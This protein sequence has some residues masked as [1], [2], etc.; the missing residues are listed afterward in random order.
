VRNGKD[1]AWSG[2]GSSTELGRRDFLVQAA[3]V[4]GA[5]ALMPD[6]LPAAPVIRGA[7]MRVAVVGLGRQGRAIIAELG[8]IEATSVAALCDS[9]PSRLEAGVRRSN[10]AAGYADHRALLEKAA[11]FD[12]IIIATPTHLHK[13]IV[14]AALAAGK[15]VYCEAPLAHTIEDAEAIAK[16]A[17]GSKSIFFSGLDA[18]SNPVYA[19][20]RGFFRTDA[21]RDT[22]SLHARWHQ[23]NSWRI[24]AS[25]PAREKA[26]N[27]RLDKE[28]S[29]GLPGELGTIQIDVFNWYTEKFPVRVMGAGS[30]RFHKDGREVHD[31]TAATFVYPDGLTLTLEHTLA[32]SYQ[33]R[34][35]VLHGSNA[36]IR[37]AA[38]HGWMFKEADAPTQG[39]EVYANRQQFHRDEGITLIAGATKLAEQGKLKEGVG[40]PNSPLWYALA[41]FV[42]SVTEGKPPASSAGDGFRATA[43]GILANRAITTGSVIEIDPKMLQSV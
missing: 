32:N 11:D 19:L 16:A 12:A 30:I 9:D 31:T 41:D 38:T 23:K 10:G 40:L 39:W 2:G 26:F 27:W 5:M 37:L 14:L 6:V 34:F 8:K 35:E 24:P 1:G 18:R 43:M 29:I 33:G 15:H 25:E 4:V 17:R 36:A 21:V 28:L 42:R 13:D 7:P 3:S 22:V 20:A